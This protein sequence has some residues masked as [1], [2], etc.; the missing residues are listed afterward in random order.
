MTP[1]AAAST[2][3]S[4]ADSRAATAAAT[5]PDS[6]PDY[7]L[8]VVGGGINGAA[9]AR[10]AAGRGLR[11][12]LVEQ[13]DLA[14]H[15]SSASSKLIH[16]GLRY[17]EYYEFGLVRKALREREVMLRSAPHLIRPLRFVVPHDPS[18]RPLWLLR[19]GLFLYDH[20]ARRELLPDSEALNLT[21]H[22]AGAALQP[23]FTR[24]FAYSDARVDDARLVV[25]NALD[26]HERGATV[27]TRTRVVAA[28]RGAGGWGVTLRDQTSGQE[29][30]VRARAL[31]NAAGP[32]VDALRQDTLKVASRHRIRLI[33]G[34]HVVV[35]RLVDHD[36]AYL[37][38]NPD[39]RILFALPFEG[40]FTVLGTTDVEQSA[41]A[42]API[43][44]DETA[45]LCAMASRWL[46]QPATPAQVCWTYSGV[47]ALLD[48]AA[49]SAAAVTRDYLLELDT[50]G[51]PVLTVFGGKIT[52]ARALAEEA[53][54]RIAGALPGRAARAAW[55]ATA[56]LPG[57]DLP[58]ADF[59]AFHADLGARYPWVEPELLR[60]WAHAYGTRVE[61]LLA[62]ARRRADLGEALAPGLHRVEVD[63]LRA[64]EWARAPDDFLWR[65]TRLGLHLS[66][67]ARAAGAARLATT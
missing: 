64:H 51:A 8:L 30:P 1:P 49:S 23:R 32:W 36:H 28:T 18:M 35:P 46:R 24:G 25:L 60:R 20:L 43:T 44:P 9:I 29:E 41:P 33:R 21:R 40:D 2:P 31:V 22:P 13:D 38:Q 57:G 14:S 39:G 7:D 27:R 65:R 15:T 62:G 5:A 12:L 54:V 53:L 48:D 4:H 66:A 10:D 17:L 55:T 34:S 37:F 3:P 6:G 50:A 52:T 63:Y 42:A 59:D 11:T 19:A 26:A 47:R 67:A 16:G 58:G 61:R 45:Y 56:P